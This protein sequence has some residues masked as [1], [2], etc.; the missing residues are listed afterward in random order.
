VPE[1]HGVVL[2]ALDGHERDA[3]KIAR[4]TGPRMQERGLSAPR[5]R[6]DDRHASRHGT[7][8]QL[9]EVIPFEQASRIS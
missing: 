9:E 2:F 7:I 5:Q 3:T 4:A 8:Q 1:A 6:R